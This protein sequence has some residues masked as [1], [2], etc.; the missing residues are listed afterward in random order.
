ML[1]ILY[2]CAHSNHVL[3]GV[4]KCC[5]ANGG[6]ELWPEVDR[7]QGH[8]RQDQG[9][10]RP[11]RAKEGA[12]SLWSLQELRISNFRASTQT[13]SYFHPNSQAQREYPRNLDSAILSLQTLSLRIDRNACDPEASES[14]VMNRWVGGDSPPASCRLCCRI[15]FNSGLP[16]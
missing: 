7:V 3:F 2:R 11:I 1:I 16:L 12:D 10:P 9:A 8:G 4:P 6:V 15:S 14:P 5:S 13:D